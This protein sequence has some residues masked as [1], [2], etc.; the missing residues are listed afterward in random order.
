MRALQFIGALAVVAAV[1]ACNQGDADNVMAPQANALTPAEVNLALGPEPDAI[2][3]DVNASDEAV[4][5]AAADNSVTESGNA[6]PADLPNE[7][8]NEANN[9]E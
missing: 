9:Q 5:N 7:A 6:P 1:A 4:G 3:N 2:A 8:V